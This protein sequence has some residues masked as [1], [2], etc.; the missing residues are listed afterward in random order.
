MGRCRV[1]N[2]KCMREHSGR[3]VAVVDFSHLIVDA[4]KETAI[5]RGF[6]RATRFRTIGRTDNWRLRRNQAGLREYAIFKKRHF[7]DGEILHEP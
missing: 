7:Q 5:L 1:F 4:G 6:Y 2:A 3:L